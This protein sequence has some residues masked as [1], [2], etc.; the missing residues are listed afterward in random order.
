MKIAST[1]DQAAPKT[2]DTHVQMLENAA[3]I[4]PPDP[5][6]PAIQSRA[7]ESGL[8]RTVRTTPHTAFQAPVTQPAMLRKALRIAPSDPKTA[9]IQSRA[10]AIGAITK[11]FTAAQAVAHVV[12]TH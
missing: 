12:V 5:N 4:V 10:R 7:L 1:P 6:R 3:R 8:I 9:P 2:P 11:F